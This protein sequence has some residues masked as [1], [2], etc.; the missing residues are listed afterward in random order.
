[1][2]ETLMKDISARRESAHL[3]I[4]CYNS[5]II[6]MI[7][8]RTRGR[9]SQ[10]AET[11]LI[12]VQSVH[13]VSDSH[14]WDIWRETPTISG[15]REGGIVEG[16]AILQVKWLSDQLSICMQSLR[17][18]TV[19]RR[20]IS[21]HNIPLSAQKG[22]NDNSSPIQHTCLEYLTV[23]SGLVCIRNLYLLALWH[24]SIRNNPTKKTPWSESA[25]ELYRP[26]DS[27]L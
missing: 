7:C 20:V 23:V 6:P 24:G 18:N 15:N 9:R 10:S 21:G 3:F 13:S 12:L 27:R 14:V 4:S 16:T 1:M 11:W 5:D 19:P 26:S 2:M 8:I 25:N 22:R 17:S